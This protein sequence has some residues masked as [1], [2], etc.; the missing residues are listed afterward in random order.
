MKEGPDLQIHMD[1][2]EKKDKQVL[3]KITES[4][5]EQY[6][7]EILKYHVGPGLYPKLYVDENGKLFVHDFNKDITL[8]EWDEI[9]R[10]LEENGDPGDP[11]YKR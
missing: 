1:L 10:K 4:E 2:K 7:Q 11:F 8:E 5:I 3:H 6:K 9:Y